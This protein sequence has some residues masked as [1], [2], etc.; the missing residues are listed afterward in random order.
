MSAV[1]SLK[2][3]YTQPRSD[4]SPITK[5]FYRFNNLCQFLI[6]TT[7]FSSHHRVKLPTSE[8]KF[9]KVENKTS[10]LARGAH[11]LFILAILRGSFKNIRLTAPILAGL[12][13]GKVA[14]NLWRKADNLDFNKEDGNAF[15]SKMSQV[16][17]SRSLDQTTLK[18][19][20]YL[21]EHD[22]FKLEDV[23]QF[24][25]TQ[26]GK[27]G[28]YVLH[29]LES[30]IDKGHFIADKHVEVQLALA[31]AY[32]GL[33]KKTEF[34]FSF[35][36]L[37]K[38]IKLLKKLAEANHKPALETWKALAA[39]NN[40]FA[41]KSL[42]DLA[43]TNASALES[44]KDLAESHKPALECLK[45][46]AAT[47]A[48]ARK[49]LSDLVLF[50]P[51][52]RFENVSQALD[53][54]IKKNHPDILDILK[55]FVKANEYEA[56]NKL[57]DLAAKDNEAAQFVLAEY[58]SLDDEK[59]LAVFKRL[60]ESTVTLK[61]SFA[62]LKSLVEANVVGTFTALTNLAR[63]G[64]AKAL[65][66]L[67]H[68][69]AFTALARL[70][71]EDCGVVTLDLQELVESRALNALKKLAKKNHVEALSSL[72]KLT[73]ENHVEALN[74]LKYLVVEEYHPGA[75]NV[76]NNL[77]ER[78]HVGANNVLS[79]LAKKY[80]PMTCSDLKVLS[81]AGD[82]QASY[83]L[84]K[85]FEEGSSTTEKSV[86]EAAKYYARAFGQDY[87]KEESLE[88]CRGLY[89]KDNK[90][91][92]VLESLAEQGYLKTLPILA[93]IYEESGKSKDETELMLEAYRKAVPHTVATF[94]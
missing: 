9:V 91:Q 72:Q 79:G 64:H 50:F 40:I 17:K 93:E 31:K 68:A 35:S 71:K 6:S 63:S 78:G 27:K 75:L 21:I 44:L 80:N 37:E 13:V 77:A 69:K 12:V 23:S 83:V 10:R 20:V 30:L 81:N 57:M 42:K 32:I 51:G 67:G 92:E 87:K 24:I 3:V 18:S 25:V 94:E 46:L 36:P 66:R 15:L 60:A 85:L 34:K 61:A 7:C 2:A 4:A 88:A 52:E 48:S 38:A 14:D 29:F 11:A 89:Q 59:A 47:N 49:A 86:L 19:F 43:A 22:L 45:T 53:G 26:I 56:R 54:L 65:A 28:Y 90:V 76:L 33:I 39:T 74:V 5:G 73:E 8:N 16:Y 41:L 70:A 58:Y 84:G 55:I 1:F 62:L 82:G